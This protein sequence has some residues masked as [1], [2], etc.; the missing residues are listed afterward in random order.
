MQSGKDTPMAV[1]S[2]IMMVRVR[3]QQA[4]GSV[5]AN[6]N[7]L[8]TTFGEIMSL[9]TPQSKQE[10]TR[11]RETFWG[12][13][14]E[15]VSLANFHRMEERTGSVLVLRY[16]IYW[17]WTPSP[18]WLKVKDKDGT[19]TRPCCVKL[20]AW[21]SSTKWCGDRTKKATP[22]PILEKCRPLEPSTQCW[23]SRSSH[24][25]TLGK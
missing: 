4:A 16:E 5:S 17:S 19:P 25:V 7:T 2:G 13:G 8:M 11:Q 3:P 22:T 23:T 15:M 21:R 1:L 14:W 18:L 12:A 20:W 24:Q 6:R 9:R 10:E